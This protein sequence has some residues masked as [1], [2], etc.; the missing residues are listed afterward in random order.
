[1]DFGQLIVLLAVAALLLGGYLVYVSRGGRRSQPT[2]SL[3]GKRPDEA[4]D[5]SKRQASLDN[6]QPNDVLVFWAGGDAIV[7]TILDCREELL[8][9]STQWRWAFLDS[10][11][12]L[13]LAPDGNT[14]FEA[15]EVFTQGS[16]T[17]DLLT[18]D[19]GRQ[20]ILK[21]FEARVRA[22]TVTT[23]PVLFDYAGVSYRIKS[24]GTFEAASR[25]KP[26]RREAWRDVSPQATDNVYFE[27]V[28]PEGQEALG[29]WT[30]HIAFHTGRPIDE[31]DIK[32]IYG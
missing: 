16:P 17:F 5:P 31:N 28:G 13:E 18:A 2:P 8:G 15:G 21:T 24:T 32:G 4:V 22:G 7:S 12:L 11:P 9:R 19:V 30:T 14:L 10:G 20:G 3:A 1:M 6:L 25:G 26:L 29:I 27:L 23:N